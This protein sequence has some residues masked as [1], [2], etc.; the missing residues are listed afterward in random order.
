M[1]EVELDMINK[2]FTIETMNKMMNLQHQLLKLDILSKQLELMISSKFYPKGRANRRWFAVR[3]AWFAFFIWK[4]M[5]RLWPDC[6]LTAT[7]LPCYRRTLCYE[8]QFMF[9]CALRERSTPSLLG[10]SSPLWLRAAAKFAK[11]SF[12]VFLVCASCPCRRSLG[13]T[14][15]TQAYR[16]EAQT[17]GWANQRRQTRT[18][19]ANCC[20]FAHVWSRTTLMNAWLH[21]IG[22]FAH[23]VMKKI[24][25]NRVYPWEELSRNTPSST[26]PPPAL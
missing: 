14:C 20:G 19:R 15:A 10:P 3:T 24:Y 11:M 9:D 25:C 22:R 8:C 7:V 12:G 26:H 13:P 21:E 1:E 23:A 2:G 5:T 17:A 18:P 16:K 6:D 4:H